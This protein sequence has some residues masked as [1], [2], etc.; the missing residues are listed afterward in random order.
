[1]LEQAS[2][3]YNATI[4]IKKD[5]Y[6]SNFDDFSGPFYGGN[7]RNDFRCYV[8]SRYYAW[9]V[10]KFIE[11]AGEKYAGMLY[12]YVRSKEKFME[13]AFPTMPF[14]DNPNV[15]LAN[16]VKEGGKISTN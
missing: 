7:M 14:G 10:G 16:I 3:F 11:E 9:Y 5:Y 12:P 6:L 15:R 4:S 2:K 1:M 13:V 8:P